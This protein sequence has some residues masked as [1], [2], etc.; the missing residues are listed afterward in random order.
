MS[1]VL[2]ILHETRAA[3]ALRAAD[4][5]WPDW[6]R[7]TAGLAL[8]LLL[9]AGLFLLLFTLGTNAAG[10]REAA[11]SL[12]TIDFAPDPPP[13]DAPQPKQAERATALPRT[14]A[15]PLPDSPVPPQPM[16]SPAAVLPIAPPTPAAEPKSSPARIKAVVR[17]QD[18]GPSG[19]PSRSSAG[20]SERV[21]TAGNGEPLY[22]ARWYR[23]PTEQE[24]RGY[25]ST[26]QG[27]GYALINCRTVADFRVE[28]CEL[29]DEYPGGAQ[30]GRA[31]LAAAWQFKVRPPQ[32]GGRSLVGAWV[33]IRITYEI[34][35][36]G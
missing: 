8:A 27:P 29:V 25:L 34:N 10:V 36:P 5:R 1:G 24:L 28:D 22:R 6:R 12:T 20:D 13:A 2:V 35:R 30:L 4:V 21:G 11:E 31:V 32:L 33:R 9:E 14:A 16:R 26:A 19:P 7:K 17:S 15:A 18:S 3:G 23:E